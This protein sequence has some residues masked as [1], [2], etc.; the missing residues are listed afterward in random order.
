[1][2][3]HNVRFR[4]LGLKKFSVCKTFLSAIP[5]V[6]SNNDGLDDNKTKVYFI[7][8]STKKLIQPLWMMISIFNIVRSYENWHRLNYLDELHQVLNEGP[9]VRNSSL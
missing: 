6:I 4:Y 8:V 1:M 7:R 2:K 9:G 5:Y 3:T